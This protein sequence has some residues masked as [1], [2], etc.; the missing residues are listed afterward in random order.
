M[1]EIVVTMVPTSTETRLLMMH[2]P[3]EVM[4]ARLSPITQAHPR[5]ATPML[6]E[7]LALWYGQRLRVV[8]SADAEDCLYELGLGDGLGVTASSMHYAIE[9]PAPRKRPP[10]RRLRGLGDFREARRQL[11]LVWLR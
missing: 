7:A 8:L 4:R 9:V 1:D 5:W 3:D 2:G 11:R 10:G 6:L